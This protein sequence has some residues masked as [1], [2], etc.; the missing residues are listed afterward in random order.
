MLRCLSPFWDL[1]SIKAPLYLRLSLLQAQ[2]SENLYRLTFGYG[3]TIKHMAA[4][5]PVHQLF[6]EEKFLQALQGFA[7]P[8]GEDKG[9]KWKTYATWQ[10]N[11][12]MSTKNPNSNWDEAVTSQISTVILKQGVESVVPVMHMSSCEVNAGTYSWGRASHITVVL[13]LLG[14]KE[15]I[16]QAEVWQTQLETNKTILLAH[17][18]W[19]GQKKPTTSYLFGFWKICSYLFFCWKCHFGGVI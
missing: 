5:L 12:I 16:I 19:G 14:C 3:S 4:A 1:L 13:P 17:L 11:I 15:W 18:V 10:A 8:D 2:P 7:V 9:T 6:D